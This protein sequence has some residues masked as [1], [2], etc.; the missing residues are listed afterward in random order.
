MEK[1]FGHNDIVAF[2]LETTGL[3]PSRDSIIEIG[4]VRLLPDGKFDRFSQL[5][6]PRCNVPF[7]I[8]ELT[9]IDNEMLED[10]PTI[11]KAIDGFLDFIG[12]AAL[13]AHNAK[14]DI[15][16]INS[17]LI[18]CGYPPLVNPAIDT[19]ELARLIYPNL[20]NHQLETVAALFRYDLKKA[21]R[22]VNDAEATLF[23]GVKLWQK[24]LSLPDP[25]FDRLG[26][27]VNAA[28]LPQIVSFWSSLR[29][30]RLRERID[31]PEV[32]TKY[33]LDLTNE[34][35]EQ[36]EKTV[37]F[38]PETVMEYFDVDSPLSEV[39]VGFTPRPEQQEMAE[40]AIGALA[41]GELLMAEAGTGVGKS[42]AY[43]IPA[44][45]WSAA[46]REKI[47]VSTY[48][49]AL[50]EQLFQSDIPTLAEIMP[51]QF[52]AVLLKGKGNYICLY[53]L[54]RYFK[55]PNLLSYR[56][57]EGLAYI[58]SW[59]VDSQ[60]GDISENTSFLNARQFYLWEKI[61][62]DGHTCVGRK[63]P[64]YDS[65]YVYKIRKKVQQAQVVVVNHALL[66]SDIG[67]GILGDYDYLIIDEAHNLERVAADN[68]G[69]MLAQWRFR[70]TL[71]SIFSESPKPS[72]TLAFLY[73]VLAKKK[74]HKELYEKAAN[75]IIAARS[76]ADTFF[77]EL[78]HQM[79]VF[80]HWR[81][82]RYGV[83]KRYD[84][85]N[86]AFRKTEPLA[87]EI[88][89]YLSSAKENLKK[90]ADSIES[91]DA[92]V[93][94]LIEE[95]NGETAKVAE[96]VE[97]VLF[98]MTPS[99]KDF[100]YWLE[101][102]RPDDKESTDARINWAPLNV[103][104]LLNKVL[105][106][107]LGAVILTSATMTVAQDFNYYLEALGLRYAPLERIRT[108]LLGSPYNY[109]DQLRIAIARFMPPPISQ[110]EQAF[111]QRVA[112]VVGECS[113]RIRLGSMVLFTNYK[114][115]RGVFENLHQ[116]M[117]TEG[118]KLLAQKIS[119]SLTALKR[120]FIENVE[121]VL[122]GTESFWQGVNIPGKSLELLFITKLPFGVP[123]EPYSEAKQERIRMQGGE[124]FTEYQVPQAVIRFRQGIGRLIRNETDKGVLI[125]LDQ[126][127]A[128]RRYGKYFLDSLPTSAVEV[129]NPE[130]L[131]SIISEQMS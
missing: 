131:Y 24:F 93:E 74:E 57:R 112:E 85:E 34:F 92:T 117:K 20:V 37:E 58:A 124:P 96:M 59:L 106:E 108:H 80:Y 110:N 25:V 27:L 3:E 49:K 22:A 38:S 116:P 88:I 53:R 16:F 79:Q 2:D 18:D 103:G 45:F 113:K 128:T 129:Y 75:S 109:H 98:S 123:D 47:V 104:E 9:G 26:F 69:G 102:P 44:L 125:L 52:K 23:A 1:V 56:E 105:Y 115:L 121:S 97:D 127:L 84:S 43:L 21:H 35:G 65:C 42:F 130:E 94:R 101:S 32:D 5:V 66:M 29:M 30:E 91:E 40:S 64:F 120:Q 76:F 63:C 36:I 82:Q 54:E 77:A 78:T 126:R 73:S 15:E 67:G 114:M 50:Q 14:F 122:L 12:D 62:A 41:N 6:N 8:T 13:L 86:P 90:F 87:A 61:R 39:L 100:V 83:R 68:L 7:F 31:E 111:V 89:R 72:G 10:A 95:L 71:D 107:H 70:S 81:E 119:G 46:N 4:A 19:L 51:F 99:E 11:D 60:S 118:V 28:N 48:T 33:L 55:N 17:N